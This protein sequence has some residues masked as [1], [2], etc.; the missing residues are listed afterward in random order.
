MKQGMAQ[1]NQGTQERTIRKPREREREDRR[2]PSNRAMARMVQISL[3]DSRYADQL[4]RYLQADPAFADCRILCGEGS[5]GGEETDEGVRV[6]DWAHLPPVSQPL[7]NPAKTVLLA[8]GAMDLKQ[9]WAT[10]IVSVLRRS[11]SLEYVKLAVLAALLRP[12]KPRL[13]SLG[14]GVNR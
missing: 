7:A 14:G 5:T 2:E 1:Q 12:A 11:E 4:C 10:G 6:I 3:E 13:P 9:V 8:T